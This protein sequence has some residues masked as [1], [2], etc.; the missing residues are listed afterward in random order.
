MEGWARDRAKRQSLG[1]TGAPT[2][3]R[4]SPPWVQWALLSVLSGPG[5]IR[6][7]KWHLCVKHLAPSTQLILSEC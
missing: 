1:I 5:A 2:G 3:Y 6:R 4:Q 7:M